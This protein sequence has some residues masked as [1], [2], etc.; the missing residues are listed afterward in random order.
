M[1]IFFIKHIRSI[2]FLV[3]AFTWNSC[4]QDIELD[5]PEED[6][7]VVIDGWIEPGR[8]AKVLLTATSNFEDPIDSA[9]YRDIVLTRAKISIIN[10]NDSETLILKKNERYFPPHI[11]ESNSIKGKVGEEY[12]ILVEYEGETVTA[13]TVIHNPVEIDTVWFE[14]QD[15]TDTLGNL[16]LQWKDS[17]ETAINYRIETKVIGEDERFV[18]AQVSSLG[19]DGFNGD[20]FKLPV[21]KGYKNAS[22]RMEEHRFTLGDTVVVRLSTIGDAEHAFWSGYDAAILN[23]G[24]PFASGGANL[25]TNVSNGL[26]NW[27]GYGSTYYTVI[28]K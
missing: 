22:S 26:G 20:L 1:A 13:T 2:A 21:Y 18:P 3:F 25:K 24:N 23:A 10:G 4:M 19:D 14:E 8:T 16:W 6:P 17:A 11:Y 9:S 28:C 7:I 15:G 5:M 27:T 12:T